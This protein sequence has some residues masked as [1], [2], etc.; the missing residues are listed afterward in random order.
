MMMM[1]MMMMMILQM[2]TTRTMLVYPT[3]THLLGQQSQEEEGQIPLAEAVA[4]P[5]FQRCTRLTSCVSWPRRS[6]LKGLSCFGGQKFPRQCA[7]KDNLLR[8]H[9]RSFHNGWWELTSMGV[10]QS[11][12]RWIPSPR[13]GWAWS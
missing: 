6:E 13:R 4:R 10:C 2:M 3:G 11:L 5:A 7:E 8:R 9:A 1:M 12:W